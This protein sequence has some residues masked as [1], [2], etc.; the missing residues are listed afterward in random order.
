MA[1]GVREEEHSERC[2]RTIVHDYPLKQLPPSLWAYLWV[3]SSSGIPAL[4]D[5]TSPSLSRAMQAGLAEVLRAASHRFVW[6]RSFRQPS[7]EE[8]VKCRKGS[9]KL[10]CIPESAKLTEEYMKRK[11]TRTISKAEMDWLY[12]EYPKNPYRRH[13][14]FLRRSQCLLRINNY[15]APRIATR[16]EVFM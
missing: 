8:I 15:S 7:H 9:C 6:H 4:K 5:L 13:E 3:L 10:L 1:Q 12:I 11:L 16:C 14:I 2:E